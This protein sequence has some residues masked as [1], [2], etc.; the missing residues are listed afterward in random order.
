MERAAYFTGA[1]LEMWLEL[2]DRWGVA[3]ALA[4]VS[5]VLAARGEGQRAARISGA[6]EALQ[7]TIAIN[8]MPEDEAM[9]APY[10][11]LARAKLGP[12]AWDAARDEGRSMPLADVIEDARV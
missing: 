9:I 5:A 12:P 4:R 10:L 8:P 11:A 6:S 3:E 7:A 2:E 1:S